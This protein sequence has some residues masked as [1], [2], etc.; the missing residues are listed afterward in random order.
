M[1]KAVI[2]AEEGR[3]SA[4]ERTLRDSGRVFVTTPWCFMCPWGKKRAI[5]LFREGQAL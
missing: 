2:D 3:R 1:F 4:E 5:F